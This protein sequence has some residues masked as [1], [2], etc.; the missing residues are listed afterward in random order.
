VYYSP[1]TRELVPTGLKIPG[2]YYPAQFYTDYTVVEYFAKH[3]DGSLYGGTSDGYLFHLD[4]ENMTLT[5]LGKPRAERRIRCLAAGK[6]GCVYLVAGERPKTSPVPC[7]FYRFDPATGGF[8]DFGLLIADR[9]PYYYRRGY[10]FDSMT[11]GL[12]GTIYLGES[13]RD[14]NLFLFLPPSP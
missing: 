2:N 3:P 1:D 9:S 14:S 12:D 4:P 8:Q 5:N 10:Q 7:K 13:E 11:T 6:N